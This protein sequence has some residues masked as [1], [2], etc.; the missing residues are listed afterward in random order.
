MSYSEIKGLW[1]LENRIEVWE[2]FRNSH[3]TAPVIWDA[4]SQKYL[5][6]EPFAYMHDRSDALWKLSDRGDI[7]L[8]HRAVLAMTFDR[9]YVAKEDYL[10]AAKDIWTFL[11]DLPPDPKYVNHWPAIARFFEGDPDCPAVGFYWTSCGDD[12][13]ELPR[14][15]DDDET[16]LP[17]DWSECWDVYSELDKQMAASA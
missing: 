7:P 12:F 16:V 3:G 11:A 13:W 15:E 9:A 8:A 2:E 5:G 10:R 1:P 4:M 14:S 6:M 17:F